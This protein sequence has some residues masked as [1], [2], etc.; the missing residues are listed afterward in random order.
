[1]GL[2]VVYFLGGG[3]ENVRDGGRD[4]IAVGWFVRM[5]EGKVFGL[6]ERGE[7]EDMYQIAD[8]RCKSFQSW[9]TSIHPHAHQYHQ[10]HK[11]NNP[12]PQNQSRKCRGPDGC[13]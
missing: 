2:L 4:I 10:R 12:T 6:G 13:E 1:M 3:W 7:R 11:N 8:K 9:Y 5:R